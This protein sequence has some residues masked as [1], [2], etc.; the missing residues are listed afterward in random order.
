M[1]QE[2]RKY[3]RFPLI[4]MITVT[5]QDGKAF[6][7]QSDNLSLGGIFLITGEPLAPGTEGVLTMMVNMGGEKKEIS[8]RFKVVH[9]NGPQK[10]LPGMG[11]EFIDLSDEAKAIIPKLK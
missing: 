8:C 5:T 4:E 6:I 7:A 3:P 2:K 11:V 1:G 9:N 10:W